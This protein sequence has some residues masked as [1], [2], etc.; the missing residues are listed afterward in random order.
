M[1]I[2]HLKNNAG[3]VVPHA[4]RKELGSHYFHPQEKIHV[5]KLKIRNPS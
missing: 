1:I 4:T 3:P 2:K 5:N